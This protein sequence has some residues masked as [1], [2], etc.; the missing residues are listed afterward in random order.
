M[1]WIK[2]RTREGRANQK[3][4]SEGFTSWPKCFFFLCCTVWFV[5]WCSCFCSCSFCAS[6]SSILKFNS[7]AIRVIMNSNF[8]PTRSSSCINF[9]ILPK[10][11]SY[12]KTYNWLKLMVITRRLVYVFEKLKLCVTQDLEHRVYKTYI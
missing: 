12:T 11:L 8:A 3:C 4:S 2:R 7:W 9:I 5:R 6:L 10:Q 1:K